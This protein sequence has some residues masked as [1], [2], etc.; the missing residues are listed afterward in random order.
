MLGDHNVWGKSAYFQPSVGVPLVIAGPGV[1]PGRIFEKAV[2][3]HDLAATFLEVA[4]LEP[5]QQ[6]DSRSLVPVLAD[7]TAT[8]RDYVLSG[9]IT[10]RR[11][12]HLVYDGRYKL[13][14]IDGE[15]P[16]LYD[17]ATDPWEE[18]N[19]AAAAPQVTA[20]MTEWLDRELG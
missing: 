4:G 17:L 7:T 9:L 1:V 16:L 14:H 10:P 19:L 13:V 20:K 3:L 12:W 18:V 6:M 15:E 11:A 2:S 8:H 5:T